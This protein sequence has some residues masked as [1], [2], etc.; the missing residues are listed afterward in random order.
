MENTITLIF[1][2]SGSISDAQMDFTLYQGQYQSKLL[3]VL[4]PTS[5]LAPQ[6]DTIVAGT[7]IKIALRATKR[8]GAIYE[9]QSY[10]MRYLKTLSMEVDGQEVEYALYER[11]LPQEFTYFAGQGENAPVIVCNAVNIDTQ[12]DEVIS[13]ITTQEFRLDVMPSSRLDNDEPIEESELTILDAKVEEL[14]AEMPLKQNKTDDTLQTTNKTIVGA[15]NDL[16]TDNTSNKENIAT[17]TENINDLDNRVSAIEQS[18]TSGETFIGSFSGT[19]LPTDAQLNTFVETRAGRP[20]QQNDVVNFTLLVE[21]ETDKN[22]KYEYSVADNSW[23]SWEIPSV[24]PASNTDKGI[25]QGSYDVSLAG[26]RKMQVNIVGGEIKNIYI[27]DNQGVQRDIYEYLNTDNGIL[28][29]IANGTTAVGKATSADNDGNGSNIALTYMTKLAGATK[30][31]LVDYALPRAFNDV[32]FVQANNILGAEIPDTQNAIYTANY[33][34]NIIDGVQLFYADKTISGMTF[35]LANKNSYSQTL[36]LSS[37]V[38]I[39]AQVRLTTQ[40]YNNNAWTT[41]NVEITEPLDFTANTIK[42]VAFGSTFNYLTSI[43]DIVDNNKIR[44]TVEALPTESTTTIFSVWSNETYPSTFYLNTTSQ[45]I[46]VATGYLG[47]IPELHATGAW[48]FVGMTQYL[49][50]TFPQGTTIQENTLCDITLTC[51]TSLITSGLPVILTNGLT[52]IQIVNTSNFGTQTD[53]DV[54][55]L[56][57]LNKTTSGSNTIFKFVSFM[58]DNR[59]YIVGGGSGGGIKEIVTDEI[60]WSTFFTN[61]PDGIYILSAPTNT[62]EI[63]IHWGI[64]DLDTETFPWNNPNQKMLMFVN[65]N[66]PTTPNFTNFYW[67]GLTIMTGGGASSIYD[68]RQR[69]DNASIHIFNALTNVPATISDLLQTRFEAIY[70]ELDLSTFLDWFYPQDTQNNKYTFVPNY[71]QSFEIK[72]DITTLMTLTYQEASTVLMTVVYHE[73]NSHDVCD[74]TIRYGDKLLFYSFDYTD[75]DVIETYSVDFANING[76]GSTPSIDNQYNITSTK[77]CLNTPTRT[78]TKATK[79]LTD[80]YAR[81]NY[82]WTDGLNIYEN[83][84]AN[85]ISSQFDR[86]QKKWVNKTWNI[87]NFEGKNVWHMGGCTYLTGYEWGTTNPIN[88]VLVDGEWQTLYVNNVSYIEGSSV[89]STQ[90][91]TYYSGGSS[92]S[93]YQI[94]QDDYDTISLYPKTW[95]NFANITGEYV[96]T[97]GKDVYYSAY[98]QQY[99]LDTTTDTWTAKTWTAL[100]SISSGFYGDKIWTDG[101]NIYCSPSS[102]TGEHFILEVSTSTWRQSAFYGYAYFDASA[103]WTDGEEIYNN[104]YKLLKKSTTKTQI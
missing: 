28:T 61:T 100:G 10:Y 30:Q 60:Y 102:A 56:D 24:E 41:A 84:P 65:G 14:L 18:S 78:F 47:E 15:I 11:Q 76:G 83:D 77:P 25:V 51:D 2:S 48:S 35:Q 31:N 32:S 43:L 81:G 80:T 71:M 92:G 46:E 62:D 16:D 42:K 67:D 50:F 63:T 12:T 5:V 1:N 23:S 52:Q 79:T 86:V 22:Y 75:V 58:Q 104:G 94:V 54:S 97:D 57:N 59:C 49:N 64:N 39:Q 27:T 6:F 19:S 93:Q 8:D 7:S 45:T 82:V 34:G 85:S 17:N 68:I 3:D 53:L 38:N 26:S 21:G 90:N 99:V 91:N 74:F 44:I 9:S 70:G 36:Y 66:Y 72:N 88:Y 95:N 98:N 101:E 96:W 33:T 13:I 87:T 69:R 55:E 103:I 89:W 40:I 73:E 4:L 20:P 29:G 37:S